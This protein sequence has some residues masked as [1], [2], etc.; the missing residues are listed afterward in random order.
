MKDTKD[1]LLLLY[2]FNGNL[3]L[4]HRQKQLEE[5]INTLNNSENLNLAL[6]PILMKP[7]LS[8]AWLSGFTDA[9]GCFNVSI[10][11]RLHTITGYRVSL[12][13]LLDQKDAE[14]TLLH[15]KN[16]FGFSFA[17][18]DAGENPDNKKKAKKWKKKKNL[19]NNKNLITKFSNK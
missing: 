18:K 12:R 2:I 6:N 15:I 9:E 3:V 19:K 13:F 16:L 1:I 4:F 11:P 10:K 14:S 8:D 5:W 17:G 7:N